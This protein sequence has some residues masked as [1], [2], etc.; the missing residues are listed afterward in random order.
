MV[1]MCRLK[2]L[3]ICKNDFVPITHISMYIIQCKYYSR[4]FLFS[5]LSITSFA[6]TLF[7]KSVSLIR[8]DTVK[9]DPG[10]FNSIIAVLAI[11]KG[12]SLKNVI[13]AASCCSFDIF[14]VPAFFS[15]VPSRS[16]FFCQNNNKLNATGISIFL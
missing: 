4:L 12:Y 7:L 8:L 6:T 13:K 3:L 2:Y 9:R 10:K 1:I 16:L 15:I 14:P 5:T 11:T